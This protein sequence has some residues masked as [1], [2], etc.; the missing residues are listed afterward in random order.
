[1]SKTALVGDTIYQIASENASEPYGR[2]LGVQCLDA[3]HFD[4]DSEVKLIILDTVNGIKVLVEE[5]DGTISDATAEF[6]ADFNKALKGWFAGPE[7]DYTPENN[8]ITEFGFRRVGTLDVL[9]NY[10]SEG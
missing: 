7:E 2:N 6:F 5:P 4:P 1:M 3:T 9:R 10:P 8:K